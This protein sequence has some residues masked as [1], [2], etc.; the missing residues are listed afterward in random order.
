MGLKPPLAQAEARLRGVNLLR[1]CLGTSPPC[2]QVSD[3]NISGAPGLF[4]LPGPVPPRVCPLA[5]LEIPFQW[6]RTVRAGDKLRSPRLAPS[7][8]PKGI[9][10]CRAERRP[11]SG[12]CL[13][14]P[15]GDYFQS[16]RSS[17]P[18]WCGRNSLSGAGV[19]AGLEM[20]PTCSV[21]VSPG[22][23]GSLG[24]GMSRLSPLGD[25]V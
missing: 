16:R 17:P 18:L 3:G 8:A 20:S 19:L 25:V 22:A 6:V 13:A 10:I 12:P 24:A 7:P 21:P 14:S 1:A 11:E 15:R 4:S 2:P 9:I 5:Q 23:G